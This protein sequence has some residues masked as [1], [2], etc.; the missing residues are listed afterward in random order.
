MSE[1]TF[2]DNPSAPQHEPKMSKRTER[3]YEGIVELGATGVL[4]LD[5]I[6][7]VRYL[8]QAARRVLGTDCID[9]SF[10]TLFDD[11]M[12]CEVFVAEVARR[13]AGS[14]SMFFAG[15]VSRDDKTMLRLEVQ[16]VNAVGDPKVD[17]IV[18]SILDATAQHSREQQLLAKATVDEL[19]GLANRSIF[20]D[21]TRSAQRSGVTGS[22]AY[23]DLDFFKKINDQF[24]HAVGDTVLQIV[25]QRLVDSLPDTVTVARLGGDEFA[26][27]LPNASTQQSQRMMLNALERVAQPIAVGIASIVPSLSVGV[28][29]L[30]GESPEGVLKDCDMAMYAAKGRGRNRVVVAGDDVRKSFDSRRE[31]VATVLRLS[32]EN[33]E[34]ENHARTDSLTGLLNR[35]A[36]SDLEGRVLQSVS[37]QWSQAAVLFVDIDHFGDYNHLYGDNGGDIALR[38]VARTL[39]NEARDTDLVFRKGGEEFAVVLPNSDF[40]SA[41]SVAQRIRCAIE[42]LNIAHADSKVSNVLTVT[43]GVG[44]VK[45][46]NHWGACSSWQVIEPWPRSVTDFGTLCMRI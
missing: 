16:A 45:R 21:R 1:P 3:F 34:L 38:A 33:E 25:G 18:L 19:T 42:S 28:A 23:G 44:G 8:N 5:R 35:R 12:R 11:P 7:I 20:L 2:A 29:G 6:G 26:I 39:A 15:G 27:L 10:A 14:G 41:L 4:V 43:I 17:G 24:G 30:E 37:C 22:V 31:L 9:V 40:P 13:S 36:L 32:L 46:V